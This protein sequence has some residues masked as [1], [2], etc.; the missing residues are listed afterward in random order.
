MAPKGWQLIFQQ[1]HHYHDNETLQGPAISAFI[2]LKLCLLQEYSLETL[3]TTRI[4]PLHSHVPR[5]RPVFCHL[6]H[7]S[8]KSLVHNLTWVS[9]C[10]HDLDMERIV[11][12][13]S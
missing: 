7:E 2:N 13:A 10:V 5:P 8:G 9:E 4:L 1:I 6:Q 11:E 12:R 3:S